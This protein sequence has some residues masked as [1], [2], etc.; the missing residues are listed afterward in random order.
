MRVCWKANL[1][2]FDATELRLRFVAGV[3]DSDDKVVN[4]LRDLDARR[5]ESSPDV[6]ALP[7][8][9][10]QG[11]QCCGEGGAHEQ[12]LCETARLDAHQCPYHFIEQY[13]GHLQRKRTPELHVD[14]EARSENDPQPFRA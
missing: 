5:I 2:Q 3:E 4:N 12:G 9:L 14:Q 1:G 10:E 13:R 8:D 6:I 7:G 11:C